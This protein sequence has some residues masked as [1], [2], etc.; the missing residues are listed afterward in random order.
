MQNIGGGNTMVFNNAARELLKATGEDVEVVSHDWWAYLIVSGCGGQ[1]FYD[2]YPSLRYRQHEGNLV[3]VNATWSARLFRIRLMWMGRF[4]SW[5]DKNIEALHRLRSNMTSEN[6]EILD[7]FVQAR[8]MSLIP[9]LVGL[10][11]SGI[12]RQ[13]LMGNIGLIAAAIFKK[14]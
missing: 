4:R 5:N 12:H 9:R 10:K 6:L 13:T 2:A 7:R 14:I 1:V 8:D 3:G 11:R